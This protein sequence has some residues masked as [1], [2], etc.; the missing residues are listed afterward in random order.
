MTDTPLGTIGD[1]IILE[2]EHVR[3]WSLR[4]EPGERQPLH[5]HDLPYIVIP[6]TEGRNEMRWPDQRVVHT[7]EKPGQ[8]L[9]RLP[10]VPH[11]LVNTSDFTY[12]NVLVE[13]K[14]PTGGE[15]K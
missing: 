15:P 12:R 14:I 8:A 11:E 13:L 2:N 9:W 1:E 6:I 7:D 10:G 5:R 4:L 3:V